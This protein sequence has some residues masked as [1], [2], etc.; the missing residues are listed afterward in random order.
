MKAIRSAEISA[1][2]RVGLAFFVVVGV[3][4][5]LLAVKPTLSGM[6]VDGHEVTA[7]FASSNK[8]EKYKSSVKIA[9]LEVGTVKDLE[10]TDDHTV[11]VRMSVDED[12]W[13]TLGSKPTARIAPRNVLAGRYTV[14]LVPGGNGEGEFNGTIP[15]TRTQVTTELDQV[16]EALPKSAVEGLQGVA[17]KGGPT[18][19][20]SE[21]SLGRLLADL[22]PALEPA[23]QVFE[24]AQGTRPA[25]DLAGVVRNGQ[26]V[27]G[28]L[29]RREG[30]LEAI[31]DD[32]DTT[33][34]VLANRSPE[35]ASVLRDLP[36]TVRTTRTGLIRL[37]STVDRLQVAA[38][39]LT[40]SAPEALRLL[41]ELEPTLRQLRPLLRD[42]RPMLRDT[43]PT[44]RELVP[45]ARSAGG[46]LGDMHGPVLDRVNG[47][48]SSFVLKPWHG[49]GP[50][51]GGGAGYLADHKFYEEVAYLATNLNRASM[52][53]DRHGSMLAFQA[54]IGADTVLEGLPGELPFTVEGIVRLALREQGVKDPGVI[55]RALRNAGVR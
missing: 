29:N 9:G 38:R 27:A 52:S 23:T 3:L 21:P 41:D 5:T 34:R 6:L 36:G 53:Q 32:L 50:Y 1:N 20:R 17:A 45:V 54:G 28:T 39:K 10:Y 47:P 48:V 55:R 18:L 22:P 24:A 13:K 12:A 51:E 49:S 31:S 7:E 4:L 16:L 14:D 43:T 11:I 44:V 33:A 46:I 19:R 8:L 25:T 42:L 26:A 2:S 30:Q 15:L 40:P 37:D 35:L